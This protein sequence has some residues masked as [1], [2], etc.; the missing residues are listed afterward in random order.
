ELAEKYRKD[1]QRVMETGEIC[2]TVEEHV[3]P[4]GQTRFVRVTKTP[5]YDSLGRANGTQAIYWDVTDER[6]AIAALAASE[7]R[8]SLAV[9]GTNDGLWD[10]DLRT[11]AIYFS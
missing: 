5:L 7:E 3:T 9:Q 1:D 8:F 10:W 4:D 11:K 6:Q 2:D